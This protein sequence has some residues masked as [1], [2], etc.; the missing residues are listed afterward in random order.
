M[1]VRAA[2]EGNVTLLKQAMLHD[3]LTAACLNPPE[4][5][6]MTDA[7][8]VA[9]AKWLPQY[10]GE[11]PAARK[12]LASEKPLGTWTWRGAARLHTRSVAEMR[13]E[14]RRKAAKK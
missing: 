7:M 14:R 11:I 12:R 10:A 3:P 4:V 1:A 5:W 2:V 13:A 8:L 9:Q 6:Q